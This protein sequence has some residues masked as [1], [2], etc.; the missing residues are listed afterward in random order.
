MSTYIVNLQSCVLYA[1]GLSNAVL[2]G[3]GVPTSNRASKEPFIRGQF[4]GL[5]N[6]QLHG[7]RF[8]I[9]SPAD[10]S[11]FYQ[12]IQNISHYPKESSV[13]FDKATRVS[14]SPPGIWSAAA[15]VDLQ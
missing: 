3:Y 1:L 5:E 14:T 4:G 10:I 9:R 6:P 13:Q 11:N 8:T 12:R 7:S 15:T 2:Y